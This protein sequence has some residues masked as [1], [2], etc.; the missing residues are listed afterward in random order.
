MAS[1]VIEPSSFSSA[2]STSDFQDSAV[3]SSR[4][5]RG[6]RGCGRTVL[7]PTDRKKSAGA[8]QP[9][10]PASSGS[11]NFASPNASIALIPRL[12]R[13][14]ATPCTSIRPSP[15]P[16]NGATTWA[17]ISRAASGETG[18]VGK[19]IERGTYAAFYSHDPGAVYPPD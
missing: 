6:Y 11:P 2:Y 19:A 13:S 3:R 14:R 18:D 12:V 8:R 5:R 1:G 10:E 9:P 17:V 16:E 7:K 15:P 4:R